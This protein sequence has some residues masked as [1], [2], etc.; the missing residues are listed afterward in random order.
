MRQLQ[1]QLN[2]ELARHLT[3]PP[4]KQ[5]RLLQILAEGF[6]RRPAYRAIRPATWRC[7]PCLKMN[8]ERLPQ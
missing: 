2:R 5:V 8:G 1:Q 6:K 3:T 4:K 7:A